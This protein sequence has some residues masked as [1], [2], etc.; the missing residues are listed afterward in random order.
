M[1]PLPTFSS[2]ALQS[3]Q[4]P[5]WSFDGF[6]SQRPISYRGPPPPP[7]PG[8]PPE[9]EDSQRETVE[10]H[11]SPRPP[12]HPS[13]QVGGNVDLIHRPSTR[14]RR[15]RPIPNPFGTREEIESEGYQS[16]V[17]IMFGRA[18][19]RYREAED[20]AR[21]SERI[22]EERRINGDPELFGTAPPQHQTVDVEAARSLHRWWDLHQSIGGGRSLTLE[23][24]LREQELRALHGH[25]PR[26]N[27]I[28]EQSSRPP[29]LSAEEMT[30][31]IACKIC[32]EQKVDT[33]LQPCMH[34]AICH[35]CSELLRRRAQ[36]QR[37]HTRVPGEDRLKCPICRADVTTARRVYLA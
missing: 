14:R 17:A 3:V 24:A 25:P 7:R 18:W 6:A 10:S 31:S 27:P 11:T 35:W 32:C 1:N 26:A 8:P 23:E 2:I 4:A 20:A 36:E 16:P 33:L 13:D 15:H 22:R 34:I 30:V 21:Q 28:D 9:R 29:P 19:N 37:R 12:R 5:S